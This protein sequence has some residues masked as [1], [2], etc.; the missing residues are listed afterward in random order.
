MQVPRAPTPQFGALPQAGQVRPGFS[1]AMSDSSQQSDQKPVLSKYARAKL[2][3]EQKKAEGEERIR[4]LQ[5][6]E[7]LRRQ[8]GGG[9]AVG[10]AH[11]QTPTQ[12]AQ[13][14]SMPVAT[15]QP[16]P[17]LLEGKQPGAQGNPAVKLEPQ[18]DQHAV[19]A[20]QRGPVAPMQTAQVRTSMVFF[21]LLPSA[22]CVRSW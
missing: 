4:K 22:F 20:S 15:P 11:P 3:K 14:L 2:R 9:A 5:E 19:A 12:V 17:K 1:Q 21:H 16:H 13:S 6:D 10:S 8:Q 7:R 18:A